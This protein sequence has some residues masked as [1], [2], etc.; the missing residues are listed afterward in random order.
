MR[1]AVQMK[2]SGFTLNEIKESAA[3]EWR[4][5][6][7]DDSAELP[8]ACEID[9]TPIPTMSDKTSYEATVFIRTKIE[10]NAN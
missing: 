10:E 9:V 4:K 1:V 6:T 3:Q 7:N 8:L 2:V 5:F